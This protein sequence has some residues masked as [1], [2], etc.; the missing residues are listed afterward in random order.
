MHFELGLRGVAWPVVLLAEEVS[1]EQEAGCMYSHPRSCPLVLVC[2]AN[3]TV[4]KER[5]GG[6][7]I[8][9]SE[10]LHDPHIW[11]LILLAP[12][13]GRLNPD[14]GIGTSSPIK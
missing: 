3:V 10:Y 11:H 12:S 5:H 9:M 2:V 13:A 14:L 4:V 8:G 7:D 6:S 1:P